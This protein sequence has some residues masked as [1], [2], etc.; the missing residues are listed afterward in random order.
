MLIIG[1]DGLSYE[2]SKSQ[3]AFWCLWSAPLLMSND[4]R[5][6]KPEFKAILQNKHL[7]AVNQ[8]PLVVMGHVVVHQG[9][10][11]VWVKKMS[12]V[13][14]GGLN[15]YAVL[16]FN[17]GYIGPPAVMSHQL[18]SLIPELKSGHKYDVHDL[19]EDNAKHE[20]LTPEQKLV[21]RVP[22]AGSVRMVK[23][24]PQ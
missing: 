17:D 15:A 21:L 7:I 5:S 9:S 4:L 16:Y 11:Q 3:M 12:P 23:L 6:I 10:K 19:F 2:Q 8:D 18:S 14:T 1:N 20:T 24:V 13:V 22:I